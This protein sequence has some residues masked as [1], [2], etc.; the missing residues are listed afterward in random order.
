MVKPV[1]DVP[2]MPPIQR[3]ASLS[4]V[5]QILAQLVRMKSVLVLLL[6]M[7]AGMVL[8]GHG[9]LAPID[10]DEARF[11]QA[12]SQMLASGDFI[13]IK[14][15]DEYRAKKPAGIYWLQTVS[16]AL[17]G[18]DDIASYRL[19]SLAGFLASLCL[20]YLI[21]RQMNLTAWGGAGP[22]MAALLLASSF[23]V[24]AEA[25]LAKTDAF[26]LALILWQQW[27]L[28]DIY[29]RRFEGQAGAAITQFWIAMS[30]TILVK[31]PI[32]PL[33]AFSTIMGLSLFDRS[34]GL[35][36]HIRLWRGLLI[37][38]IIVAPWAISVQIA[39]N[40][41]FLDIAIKADFLAKVQS[42][43]ES[44][45]APFGTY[46]LIL[47]LISF[48]ASLFFSQLAL[49]DTATW[50]Y[51][52]VRFL[53]AWAAGYWVLIEA[54]PTKLPHYILPALPA[55][56][57][58]VLVAFLHAAAES[59]PRRI[60]RLIIAAIAGVSG[61]LLSGFLVY[62]ALR[63]GS[64]NAFFLSLLGVL[65]TGGCLVLWWHWYKAPQSGVMMLTLM[66]GVLLHMVVISGILSASHQL[67]VSTAL[68]KEVMKIAATPPVIG[69]AGYHE[70][71]MVFLLGKDTL[72]ITEQEAALL[73]AEAPQ[74][75]AII[76][77]RKKQ[78][79]Y[80]TIQKLGI[81][82]TEVGRVTGFNISRGQD[83]TLLLYQRRP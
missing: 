39:T 37:T 28:F 75:L 10:R 36:R 41:A 50:R 81:S 43:Q 42:G 83:V 18:E 35:W 46:L 16:A 47:G 66:G 40:G 45:G 24:Y 34:L 49:F 21:A 19:P 27:A 13:T 51:D 23:I 55:L 44:H 69:A 73:L 82:G 30:L 64:G 3:P 25:H 2:V 68:Q 20:I 1:G 5:G 53:V 78:A 80:D 26:L 14:F 63:F 6:L 58:L 76:E 61:L 9:Q 12:S 60:A 71:S 31:G 33:V 70:P 15:Q 29:R 32:G 77:G 79:F 38:A 57:L 56:F 59:K 22:L 7:V 48:P 17:F 74:S 65:I 62:G 67:H 8:W 11:A 72:L 4:D 54:T 52:K